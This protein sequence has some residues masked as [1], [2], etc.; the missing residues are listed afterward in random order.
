MKRRF[1]VFYRSIHRCQTN[2][3]MKKITTVL[4]L[5]ALLLLGACASTPTAPSMLVLPGSTKNFEQ[6]RVDDI[7]CR[8][9]AQMQIGSNSAEL[10]QQDSIARS[11]IVGTVLGAVAGA[12]INGGHGAGVGAGAGLA[13]GGLSGAS[14]SQGTGYNLQQRYDISY[15]QCMYAK[16]NQIPSYGTGNRRVVRPDARQMSAYPAPAQGAYPSGSQPAYPASSS[17]PAQTGYPAPPP[18][19]EGPPPLPPS[20]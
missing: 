17:Y 12:A 3:A 6:F 2:A 4:P 9:Y 5:G 8:Q 20:R 14:S 18:P 11:A 15:Q 13:L 10:A 19:P 1:I 16:G 7:D